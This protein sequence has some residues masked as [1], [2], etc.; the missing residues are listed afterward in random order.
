[1]NSSQNVNA[2]KTQSVQLEEKPFGKE[3]AGIIDISRSCQGPPTQSELVSYPRNNE[4]R[5]FIAKWF[6]GRPSSNKGNFLE[7]LKWASLA[8]PI[9]KSIFEDTTR[10]STYLSGGIQNELIKTM[11]DQVRQQITETI[12]GNTFAL[13]ADESRDSGDHEQL[14]IVVRVVAHTDDDKDIIPEYFLGLIRLHEFDAQTL[15]NEIA[16]YLIKYGIK[17]ESCISQC[18]D[19]ASAMAGKLAGLQTILRQNH[20]PN[21][22]YIHCHAHRLNLA[23]VNG[24]SDIRWDSRW[25]SIHAIMVNYESIVVALKDLID[26]DGH[27]SIDARGILSAI[28]EPV[29]IVIMFA[30]N[31]LFGSIKILSDQLKGESID[32]A[33]SQQLITSVIEQIECDRNEKSYKTMYFN[34]LNFAEK[35]DIDMNQKSKQKRPKIIPT[36]FK[37]TFLTST[38]GHR[39]EI[40][41]ED[42]YRD[43]I[44]I[45]H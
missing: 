25:S 32:Y 4:N 5:S 40:I 43:I 34:I 7:I 6:D 9:V 20:M 36:R 35:Y 15:S 16:N 29:F 23:I 39:T 8:D 18:Y 45:I 14:S 1:M 38:I 10:N 30:L 17:L 22:I 24:W 42:D 27:R 37:D 11:I 31:K 41:N 33:E 12:T 19:G 3:Y 21:G 26:E 13:W 2:K 44:Y 28:Q